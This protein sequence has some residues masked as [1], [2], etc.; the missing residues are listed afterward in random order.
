MWP[1][2]AKWK[3]VAKN[4]ESLD[5]EL[6]GQVYEKRRIAVCTGSMCQD[7]SVIVLVLGA[8][9]KSSNAPYE[10]FLT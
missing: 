2:L 10:N 5:A 9:E 8:M 1:H 3:I 7:Q 4:R 6:L